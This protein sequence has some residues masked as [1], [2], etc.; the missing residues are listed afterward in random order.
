MNKNIFILMLSMCILCL[1]S[2]VGLTQSVYFDDSDSNIMKLGNSSYYEIGFRK[3]NGSI[4]Y[5]KDK[6]TG[7]II[8]PGSRNEDLWVVHYPDQNWASVLGSQ[9]KLSGPYRFSY[10]WLDAAGILKLEYTPRD[11]VTKKVTAAVEV[12]PSEGSYFDLTISISNEYGAPI[13]Y[14][15]FP[16]NIVF[17]ENEIEE[18][19]LP[20]TPGVILEPSFFL[21]SRTYVTHFPGWPGVFA[22][23]VSIKSQ[24]GSYAAYSLYDTEQSIPYIYI[25]FT[26]D[27]E[28]IANSTLCRHTFRT[29]VPDDQEWTSLITRIHIGRSH[30]DVIETFRVDNGV[31]LF[32]S[33]AEKLSENFTRVAQSPFLNVDFQIKFSEY[34]KILELLPSPAIIHPPC[35]YPGG[36][37]HNYPD[38]LPPDPNFGTTEELKALFERAQAKGIMVMPYTNPTWWDDDSPTVQNEL[39]PLTFTDI[40][41]LDK[42]GQPRIEIYGDSDG[43]VVSPWSPFVIQRIDRLMTEMTVDVPSDFIFEDQVGARALPLDFNPAAGTPM[44]YQQGWF[45]HTKKHAALGLGTECGYDRLLETEIFFFGS[46]LLHKEIGSTEN[47]W[48]DNNWHNYPLTS[49]MAGDKILFHQH[50]LDGRLMTRSLDLLS[51]SLAYGFMLSH[52]VEN[53]PNSITAWLGVA[54][55]FQSRVAGRYAG[56]KMIDYVELQDGVTQSTFPSVTVTTNWDTTSSYPYNS[57]IIPPKGS[58]VTGNYGS[59]TA[60]IFNTYN[61][62]ALTSGDHYLIIECFFDGD[63]ISIRQPMGE[64]TPI[65]LD[66]QSLSSTTNLHCYGFA[67]ENIFEVAIDVDGQFGSFDWNRYHN[68]EEVN[69]YVVTVTPLYLIAPELTEPAHWATITT[70]NP[71][72]K[73]EIVE[74]AAAYQVQ[75]STDKT[76]AQTTIDSAAITQ[77]QFTAAGLEAGVTYFWRVSASNEAHTSDW[78]AVRRFRIEGINIADRLVAY[79][80]LNGSPEDS[81]GD[82][83]GTLMGDVT[84]VPDQFG[85]ANFAYSFDGDGDYIEF[86]E[87]EAF[88]SIDRQITVSC[89][90]NPRSFVF[91]M[92]LMIRDRFWRLMLN[93]NGSVFGNIF[94]EVNEENRLAGNDQVPLETWSLA[95]FTYDGQTIRVYVNG[96]LSGE[97]EYPVARIGQEDMSSIPTL[98]KGIGLTQ[99]Y[100]DGFIDD[101]RVYDRALTTAEMA[102]LYQKTSTLCLLGDVNMDEAITPGDALCAFQIYM[103]GGTV[104]PG[105]CDNDCA[106]ETADASCNGSIT[107]G[108]A[109]IIFQAYLDGLQPPLECPPTLILAKSEETVNLELSL[110]NVNKNTG[111]EFAVT[112]IVDS[113]QGLQA[114]GLDLGYPDE[115]LS[116]VKVSAATLTK[117]W[118]ALDGK[119][120]VPGTVSIG[121]FNTEKISSVKS[122]VLAEVT[123]KKKEGAEGFG[124]LWLFNLTDDVTAAEVQCGMYSTAINGVRTISGDIPTS[125]ALQQNYPNPFNMATEIVYQLPE[126]VYVNLTIYNSLGHKI[127]T[128][129]SREQGAGKYAAHWNGRDEQGNNIS[130][131]IYFYRLET[132]Q[133]S[134]VKKMALV[135]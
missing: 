13:E 122:S 111:D 62:A 2:S 120:N 3:T 25:G 49:L 83:H 108:D 59:L 89:W 41:V 16:C 4:S 75:I 129:I 88:I 12:Q 103:N 105:E 112:I 20:I 48:G 121:G 80:P 57:H 106:L 81:V 9:Y 30:K 93:W 21:E 86:P 63:S 38:F 116:F 17:A 104:A 15:Q 110:A 24:H 84:P 51:W 95:A 91:E 23:F 42:E 6:T 44:S 126:A 119:E 74:G 135:K 18:A 107:P 46:T 87:S 130:S 67:G 64:D 132:A 117:D 114:F 61:D 36:F 66:L 5:I 115:L 28:Y 65:K 118:Q 125:F 8:S 100:F 58:I 133:F 10:K 123:F 35:Y 47:Y 50:N 92:G 52:L 97:L 33:V 27:D 34:D 60:G 90:I 22:D 53:H 127:R 94:N 134:N 40:A 102:E 109:L 32:S 54:T 82:S 19:L 98:G 43:I 128:L 14:V 69:R 29:Y 71:A 11:Y 99:K 37:D 73:W 131:G 77:T 55:Q 124:D 68:S 72:L 96:Q 39:P 113:P 56:E 31:D 101:V 70:P 26:D 45:E 79:Y 76:F 1:L 7:N 85:N 78:S